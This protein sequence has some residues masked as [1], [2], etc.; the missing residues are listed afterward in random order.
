MPKSPLRDFQVD[1]AHVLIYQTKLDTSEAA[2]THAASILRSTLAKRGSARVIVGTG[3]S[4]DDMI[5]TLVET[6]GLD[7]NR[8]EVFH[9]DEY[10]GMPMSIPP[11]S[12]L[13]EDTSGGY[14]PSGE[15]ALFAGRRDRFSSGM[16]ALCRGAPFRPHRCLL[17]RLWRKWAHCFST[18]PLWPIPRS[19][20]CER[21]TRI[22]AAGCNKW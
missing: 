19:P 12:A 14:R 1:K 20:G 11:A 21:V 17:Y 13:A 15:S 2:A 10:V 18:I 6:P 16:R 22:S 4:Q 9:M 7:W 3:N 8:I 5:R